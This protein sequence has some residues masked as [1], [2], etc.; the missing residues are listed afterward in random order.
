MQS[1]KFR[2]CT[3]YLTP[4][5]FNYAGIRPKKWFNFSEIVQ[6]PAPCCSL[7]VPPPWYSLKM[8]WCWVSGIGQ[9][10]GWRCCQKK[11]DGSC[12]WKLQGVPQLM[13]VC[14]RSPCYLSL[15]RERLC[16]ANNCV[17]LCIISVVFIASVSFFIW[18]PFETMVRRLTVLVLTVPLVF[19]FPLCLLFG[20]ARL[21]VP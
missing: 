3:K 17:G 13:P 15:I 16:S 7:S 8:R 4:R 2:P 6:N 9:S 14:N 11:C 19:F 5:H 21:F 1:T 12:D 10:K 20:T 18:K